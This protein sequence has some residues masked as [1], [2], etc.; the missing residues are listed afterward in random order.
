MH[1]NKLQA[2]QLFDGYRFHQN[3]VLVLKEDGT[4]EA[5]I[6]PSEAG[7]D[8]Q[9]AGGILAPGFINCHC[10]LELSHLKGRIP[11]NTGLA[12][13]VRQVVQK[14]DFTESAI[15]QA[16]ADAE[17]EMRQNGIVAVGDI[18]NTTYTLPQKKQNHLYYHNFIEAMGAD[19]AVADKNFEFY[20]TVYHQFTGLLTPLQVSIV[21]HAPYSVSN[22][23]W[24]KI[25]NYPQ[26]QLFSIHNQE[27]A[28]ENRWFEQKSGGFADMF[29]AMGLNMDFFQ[30]SGKTSLQ[31]Y[32]PV[33]R[34]GQQVLLVHN[35]HTSEADIK[36]VQQSGTDFYWCLCPNANE[37]ISRAQPPVGL[38]IKNDCNIV[39]G[40]DSLASNHQLNIW[41]EIKTLQRHFPELS[42]E[43]M[44]SWATINGAKAL[45]IEKQYGSFE[46]GKKPGIAIITLS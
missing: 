45:K 7:D 30:P 24:K 39:L 32:L 21:P 37:Y 46:K 26:N 43:R 33:F 19:P 6:D 5:I 23:L 44:L 35:V 8:V 14:R 42:L 12:G 10:H 36:Q 15:F 9:M 27:T 16:I 22:P 25:L 40:T 13:F 1:F 3:K 38:L 31:T 29:K 18:C 11:E 2:A 41:E 34:S 4:V 17:Q 20:K 28:D